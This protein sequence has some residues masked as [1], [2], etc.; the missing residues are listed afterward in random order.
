ME[1]SELIT[2]EDRTEQFYV[3]D[4]AMKYLK[5]VWIGLR[6]IENVRI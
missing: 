4:Q 5:S 2:I 6:Y 3:N 1:D